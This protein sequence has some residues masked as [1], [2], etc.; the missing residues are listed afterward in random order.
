MCTHGC[1]KEPTGPKTGNVLRAQTRRDE[2][3]GSGLSRAD[4]DDDEQRRSGFTSAAGWRAL[5]P[6]RTVYLISV[7]S[8]VW[9]SVL[10]QTHEANAAVLIRGSG[11]LSQEAIIKASPGISPGAVASTF[12]PLS[13]SAT[14]AVEG[15][16]FFTLPEVLME[17]AT[18]R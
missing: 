12:H 9:D 16:V 11:P 1:A 14:P 5:D 18:C 15:C 4:D 10:N 7:K 8:S 13:G 3:A 2:P 6:E 17:T